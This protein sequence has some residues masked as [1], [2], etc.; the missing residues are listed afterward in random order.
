MVGR[1]DPRSMIQRA[2]RELHGRT[3]RH[4]SASTV[5]CFALHGFSLPR[6]PA[7]HPRPGEIA[8]T[9]EHPQR[10]LA[11]GFPFPKAVRQVQGIVRPEEDEAERERDARDDQGGE[12][13]EVD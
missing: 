7:I 5:G 11:H 3:D 8:Q 13:E 12:E 4:R 10:D 9:E 1:N 2:K 6:A